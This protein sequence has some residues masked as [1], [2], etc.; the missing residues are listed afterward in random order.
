V[1]AEAAALDAALDAWRPPAATADLREK[2]LATAPKP[3]MAPRWAGLWLSGAGLAAAC[4]AGLIVGIAGS[5][6]AVHD[7][8]A[9]DLMAAATPEDASAAFIPFTVSDRQVPGRDA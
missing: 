6:A 4:A 3:R 8:R 5:S 7:A 2:V 9:D 1:L